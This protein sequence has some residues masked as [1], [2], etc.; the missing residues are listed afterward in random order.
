MVIS[1]T[2]YSCSYDFCCSALLQEWID[3]HSD[4]VAIVDGAN[5]GLYQ[6]NF[7]DGGFSVAQVKHF[8]LL[9]FLELFLFA[10]SCIQFICETKLIL[11]LYSSLA[12][13]L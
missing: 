6:Q 7:A 13:E 4:Y 11:S 12:M 8:Y 9:P 3:N 1:I 10:C 5:I 2:C